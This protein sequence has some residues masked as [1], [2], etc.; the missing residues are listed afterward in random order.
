ML[1]SIIVIPLNTGAIKKSKLSHKK[2]TILHKEGIHVV[3]GRDT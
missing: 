2:D 1:N 3:T